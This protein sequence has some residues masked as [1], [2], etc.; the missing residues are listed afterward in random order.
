M[1]MAIKSKVH[2]VLLPKLLQAFPSHGL[3]KWA[4]QAII[5]GRGIPKDTMSSEDQPWLF[6][7]ICWSKAMLNEFVLF[8]SF[9]PIMLTVSY[10]KAKHAIIRGVPCIFIDFIWE[11]DKTAYKRNCSTEK[12]A[13]LKTMDQ[14]DLLDQL[15][16]GLDSFLNQSKQTQKCLQLI[17]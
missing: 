2:L 17:G 4:F 1:D 14:A 12:K 5:R 3:F 9:P 8:W 13:T 15:W 10:T 16:E 7:S 11:L 6:L